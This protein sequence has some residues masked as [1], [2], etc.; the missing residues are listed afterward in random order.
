MLRKKSKS[1][2]SLLDT[3]F[4]IVNCWHI[5]SPLFKVYRRHLK[6]IK[7]QRYLYISDQ[8]KTK[9]IKRSDRTSECT[10]S[11][12]QA[13][14]L[15]L[16]SNQFTYTEHAIGNKFGHRTKFR[17]R[18]FFLTVFH[19]SPLQE[20]KMLTIV[21]PSDFHHCTRLLRQ[22]LSQQRKIWYMEL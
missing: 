3:V 4:Y 16:F 6:F 2:C 8:S 21:I 22:K 19:I 9:S 13:E 5:M 20:T 1:N 18:F 12:L 15:N 11:S 17:F 10:A 14:R 7:K